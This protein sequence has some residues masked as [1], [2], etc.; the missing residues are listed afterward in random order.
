MAKITTKN[1]LRKLLISRIK[2]DLS[3]WRGLAGIWRDKKI[4]GP[5]QWQRKIRQEWER[6]IL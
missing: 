2:R 3:A 6:K 5:I 1:Y 4:T